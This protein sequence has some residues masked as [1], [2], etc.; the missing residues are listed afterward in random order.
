MT[1]KQFLILGGAFLAAAI[2]WFFLRDLAGQTSNIAWTAAIT[3]FTAILWV[4]EVI[5]IPATSLI[6]FALFPFAGVLSHKEV[7]SA[8]GSHVILLLMGAFM[9]SKSLEKSGVHE[10]LAVYMVNLVGANSGRRVVIGFMLAA[11]FL[12]MWISNTATTLML[13]PIAMAVLQYVDD[14]AMG[15]ALILGIA[16]AA[17]LGGIGTPIGTPPNI[18]FIS[19]YQETTGKEIDFVSWM[20][21]A[22]PI[23][24]LVLPLM[25]LWL[26]RNVSIKQAFHLPEIGRWRSE[27]KRVLIVFGLIATAWVTRKIWSDWF[28]LS[29]VGDSTVAL[30]GVVLMFLIPSGEKH[31]ALLDWRSARDIPW[32]MLLLFAGGIAI[33]KAF[34]ASGLSEQLGAMLS[35]L[36]TLPLWALILSLCLFV[37]F[38]TEITSNTATATL[39]MPVLAAAGIAAGVDPKLLMMPAAISASCAFMLPVATAPNA[40]AYGTGKLHIKDMVKEGAVLNV[41]VALFVSGV[42]YFMLE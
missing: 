5:P 19:V 16:Y 40:I 4:T 9:L 15:I 36:S 32:G 42:C 26:T 41:V 1:Q 21:I 39:L 11:A 38:L 34:K 3:L 14:A 12:S 8:L 18:I 13:I 20:K 35:D 29:T 7:A 6:P 37:T 25:A 28:G 22:V 24:I 31:E 27:E 23:V 2:F 17:S 10:R 33:A 30:M